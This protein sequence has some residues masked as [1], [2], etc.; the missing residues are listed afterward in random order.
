[1]R[2]SNFGFYFEIEEK[3]DDDESENDVKNV[4]NINVRVYLKELQLH[5]NYDY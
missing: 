4:A 5:R 1:M 2:I 3:L